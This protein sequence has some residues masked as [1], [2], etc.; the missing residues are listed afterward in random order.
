MGPHYNIKTYNFNSSE[1]HWFQFLCITMCDILPKTDK[2][3][4][5]N[6]PLVTIR[7]TG[8]MLVKD[9]VVLN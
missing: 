3:L 8:K 4:N 7:K 5:P 6:K 1:G 9:H 2:I